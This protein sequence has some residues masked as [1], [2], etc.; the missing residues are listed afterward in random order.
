MIK[1]EKTIY[2]ILALVVISWGLNI[3]MVKYLTQSISPMLV[4]AIRMPLAGIVLLPF[5]WKKYGFYKPNMKQWGLLLLIGVTSIFFHQLFLA[6]GVVTTTAT[7]ASLILGLNP[8]STALLAS[9]FIGEKF[10][11]RLALG[12]LFGF[13]G[14]VL[15]VT[16]KSAGSSIGLSGWGDLIMFLSMLAY[17]IGGLFIKKLSATAIPTLV[18]TAYSTV[19]G[20]VLLNLGTLTMLGPSSYDQVHLSVT[21]WAVM[22]MSAWGASSLGTLGWNHGIKFLGANKTAM[23]LNGLPFASMVGGVIFLDEHI[24]WIHVTAFILTTFGIV[25][26]TLKKRDSSLTPAGGSSVKY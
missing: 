3:V 8:L 5:V 25:I 18:V 13:S 24:G 10:N 26:G 7:N 2:F 16:S 4:A 22:L 6:Y 11:M 9:M 14:V 23:F 12:I 1:Q 21:A 17:V 19:I 20:G 15:V